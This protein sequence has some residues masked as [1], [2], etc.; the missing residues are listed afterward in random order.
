VRVGGDRPIGVEALGHNM[1]AMSG[2]LLVLAT[3]LLLPA[4]V[5]GAL[6]LTLEPGWGW[7]AAV[8]AAA[9]AVPVAAAEAHL[10]LARLGRVFEATDPSSVAP[11][12]A[13]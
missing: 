13:L 7:W 3:L 12:E 8:P 10:L 1:L 6:F 9:A 11:V 2:F 4:A 5:A